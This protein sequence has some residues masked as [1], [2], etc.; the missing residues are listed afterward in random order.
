MKRLISLLIAMIMIFSLAACGKSNASSDRDDNSTDSSDTNSSISQSDFFEVYERFNELVGY[1]NAPDGNFIIADME[2]SHTAYLCIGMWDTEY[3]TGYSIV[4]DLSFSSEEELTAVV[5][6]DNNENDVVIDCSQLLEN[7]RIRVRIGQG[8][9]VQ[10]VYAGAI[11]VQAYQHY[12]NSMQ[13]NDVGS[14]PD[15]S[16]EFDFFELYEQFSRLVGY[17]NA[18]ENDFAIL[19][20]ED[21]H[22]ACFAYGMYETG[23]CTDYGRINNLTALGEDAFT[24]L[25]TWTN[26]EQELIIDYSGLERD[27]KI[28]IKLGNGEWKQYTY[29]GATF[30]EAYQTFCNNMY[31][32]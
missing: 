11:E 3:C 24:A 7:K 27:G 8:D 25:V 16:A 32:T 6:W 14:Q 2:D 10:Y 21:S 28:R 18:S 4:T 20:M 23:F 26:E 17:W 22:T 9:W 1:W 5:T 30:D 19:D 15:A 31:G 12:L 29:A 13:G